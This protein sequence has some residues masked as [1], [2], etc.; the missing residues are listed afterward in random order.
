MSRITGVCLRAAALAGLLGS[1]LVAVVVPTAA[2]ATITVTTTAD[3][4]DGGDGQTSLREA[5]ADASSNGVDDTITLGAGLTYTLTDCS[6]PLTHAD[7]HELVVQGNNSTIEQSCD[8]KAI[9]DSTDHATASNC[10]T[11]SLLVG[12]TPRTPAS[13]VPRSA[14]TANCC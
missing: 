9:I 3:T 14:P 8:A 1:G 6:G 13:K 2:A 5:F 10:R 12:R 7:G 11:W 4:V